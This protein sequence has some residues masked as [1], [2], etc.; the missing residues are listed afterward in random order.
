MNKNILVVASHPDDEAI[1]CGGTIAKHVE[2]KDSVHLVF[3]SDGVTSRKSSSKKELKLRTNAA[4]LSARNVADAGMTG[5]ITSSAD[6]QANRRVEI[7]IY[8]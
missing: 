8:K 3:M 5:D 7:E 1:G 4:N 6:R 2:K